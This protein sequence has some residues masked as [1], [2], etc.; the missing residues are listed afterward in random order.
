MVLS[1]TGVQHV[2]FEGYGPEGAVVLL[3]CLTEDPERLREALRHTFREHGGFLGAEGAVSYL[4]D[5][6]GWMRFAARDSGRLAAAAYAAGAES[7][8]SAENEVLEVRTDPQDFESIRLVLA[9]EGWVPSAAA[10]SVRTTQVPRLSANAALRCRE[11][12]EALAQIEDVRH[13]Y[14]NVPISDPRLASV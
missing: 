13:V 4:F 6:V 1:P 5:R 10:V 2:R 11:L 7:V 3:E 9:R 8:C 14:S 12:L